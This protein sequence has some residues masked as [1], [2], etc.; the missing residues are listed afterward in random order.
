VDT[1]RRRERFREG[2]PDAPVRQSNRGHRDCV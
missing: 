2:Q 1:D